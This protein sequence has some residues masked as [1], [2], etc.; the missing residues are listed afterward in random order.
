MAQLPPN[1]LEALQNMP[2]SE[3]REIA[4]KWAANGGWYANV[5][6]NGTEE[7]KV[8]AI[9]A[10]KAINN[11]VD[12]QK[13]IA[14]YDELRKVSVRLPARKQ[15]GRRIRKSSRTSAGK[16]ASFPL[17]RSMKGIDNTCEKVYD[18]QN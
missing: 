10:L 9:Y 8:K 14:L 3:A 12:G 18:I 1:P 4:N 17:L 16:E 15:A 5:M 11:S 2:E 6:A 13:Q 7:D